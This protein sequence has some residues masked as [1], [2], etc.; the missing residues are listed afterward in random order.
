MVDKKGV[1]LG[2]PLLVI[3]VFIVFI[4]S[5]DKQIDIEDIYFSCEE[6]IFIDLSANWHFE[7]CL[8]DTTV[9]NGYEWDEPTILE[10]RRINMK[11]NY[12]TKYEK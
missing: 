11:I 9:W 8:D 6:V 5:N 12:K 2:V 10:R 1:F 4:F 3:F 7:A